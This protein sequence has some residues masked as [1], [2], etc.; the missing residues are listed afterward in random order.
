MSFSIIPSKILTTKDIL[1]ALK[2][3]YYAKNVIV[4]VLPYDFLPKHPTYP[5]AYVV[6]SEPA[7][8]SGEH[9]FALY[10]N[11]LGKCSFFDSYG[12]HPSFFGLDKYIQR[13]STSYE[14]NS[15]QIQNFM[16]TTCGYYCI[17]FVLLKSRRFELID[18]INLFDKKN[19]NINDFLVRNIL[20]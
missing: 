20:Q 11:E 1:K 6:N 5:R 14:F 15:V 3:D 4:G 2:C 9:W 10:Y 13:T 19:F 17:Y 12:K 7:G 8:K 16:S 18:I